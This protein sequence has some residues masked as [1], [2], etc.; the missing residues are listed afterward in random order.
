MSIIVLK[1]VM[2]ILSETTTYDWTALVGTPATTGI[3]G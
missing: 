1:N 3:F 2:S